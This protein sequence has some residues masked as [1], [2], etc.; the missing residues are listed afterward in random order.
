[1]S[2]D[3]SQHFQYECMLRVAR[4]KLSGL[5]FRPTASAA[6][7]SVIIL[8]WLC[9]L[10]FGHKVPGGDSASQTVVQPLSY[11]ARGCQRLRDSQS[12]FFGAWL[13]FLTMI[14]F[15][16]GIRP[17][18]FDCFFGPRSPWCLCFVSQIIAE[19]RTMKSPKSPCFCRETAK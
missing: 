6:H 12:D 3:V 13:G 2:C 17:R 18:S 15:T 14:S 1:M 7:S 11:A 19:P 10:P 5:F 8:A 16:L 9:P 4:P